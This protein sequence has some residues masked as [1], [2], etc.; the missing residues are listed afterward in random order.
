[1]KYLQIIIL[2]FFTKTFVSQNNR[3]DFEFGHE[4]S[5]EFYF[6]FIKD[7]TPFIDLTKSKYFLKRKELKINSITVRHV[8]MSLDSLFSKDKTAFQYLINTGAYD[9]GYSYVEIYHFDKNGYTMSKDRYPSTIHLLKSD[10]TTFNQR[11]M[12]STKVGD[13]LLVWQYFKDSLWSKTVYLKNIIYTINKVAITTGTYDSIRKVHSSKTLGYK[14]FPTRYF[15]TNDNK[16]ARVKCE[17]TEHNLYDMTFKFPTNNSIIIN[18]SIQSFPFDSIKHFE[19]EILKS[20]SGHIIKSTFYYTGIPDN[21]SCYNFQY[22]KHDNLF[23]I[24]RRSKAKDWFDYS[25]NLYEFKHSYKNNK[26]IKTVAHN[27]FRVVYNDIIYL[28]NDIGLVNEIQ[29]GDYK[30]KYEYNFDTN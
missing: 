6:E 26:L 16:I 7:N 27:N 22:D 19:N 29:I 8:G 11:R 21:Y 25:E 5:D 10:T 9:H 30:T 17:N 1:V 18:C 14:F 2:L 4:L 12:N 24:T 3:S 15:F 13:S 28:Y 23:K 20:S